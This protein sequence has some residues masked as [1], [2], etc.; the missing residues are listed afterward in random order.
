MAYSHDNVAHNWAHKTGER[1]N[2]FN[3]FYSG[4]TIYS[5]G[6]HYPI[7]RFVDPPSPYV[8][9]NHPAQEQDK[10]IRQVILFNSE[11]YSVS[12]SK[13]CTIVRR[14]IPE[15]IDHVFHIP[16]VESRFVNS[17][18]SHQDNYKYL[19]SMVKTSLDLASRARSRK[20]EHI[21]SANHYRTE[22]N[23]YSRVFKLGHRQI[24]MPENIEE[25]IRLEKIR[26]DTAKRKKDE[27]DKKKI[28]AWLAGDDIYPPHTRIP[29]VR[30][31][32]DQVQTSWGV[33]VPLR[34]AI[35][36]YRL[37]LACNRRARAFEP[38]KRHNVNG[39]RLNRISADGTLHVG[40]HIIPLKI[41]AI[42]AKQI[43]LAS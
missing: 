34:Q 41:Q 1:R 27:S 18:T 42:A 10:A 29:Y 6:T 32:A 43:E 31:R 40:C 20:M 24:A 19:V 26:I 25:V 15:Y 14:A 30:V 35:A 13:H 38:H 28:R 5:Y 17:K 36:L 23:L 12:T 39:W 8:S 2:G 33:S 3:M 21:G 7:A 37:A 4:P 11:S 22:A 9:A 16:F